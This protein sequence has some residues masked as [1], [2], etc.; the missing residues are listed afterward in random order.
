MADHDQDPPLILDQAR[1]LDQV[2]HAQRG[3]LHGVAVGIKDVFDT[4]GASQSRS[5][6]GHR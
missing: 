5:G 1:A 6:L 3:P 2:P 4:K